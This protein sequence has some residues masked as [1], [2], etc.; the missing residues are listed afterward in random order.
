VQRERAYRIALGAVLAAVFRLR[1]LGA[2]SFRLD[3]IFQGRALESY[4]RSGRDDW[5]HLLAV[6]RAAPSS[7]PIYT[8]AHN[9]QYCIAYYFCGPTWLTD[10]HRCG[11]R[12]VNLEGDVTV[13]AA[14]KSRGESARLVL[15]GAPDSAA[16]RAWAADLPGPSFPE[17]E[18]CTLKRIGGASPR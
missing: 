2:V 8:S 14:A 1:H 10:G 4:Y 15:D 12:L 6:L 7:E 3:E 13:L 17:A 11:R 9:P 18:G 16:P 5:S